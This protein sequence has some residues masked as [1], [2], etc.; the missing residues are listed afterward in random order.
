MNHCNTFLDFS[1]VRKYI[2]A[3]FYGNFASLRG[4]FGEDEKPW[5]RQKP[6]Q[7]SNGDN[8]KIFSVTGTI[9]QI[10]WVFLNICL[11]P[12]KKDWIKNEKYFQDLR[13]FAWLQFSCTD[14]RRFKTYK[15]SRIFSFWF[16]ALINLN[17]QGC[18]IAIAT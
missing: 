7:L 5:T 17:Y 15:Y 1:E 10:I 9:F 11:P 3:S 14:A 6:N 16:D 8:A 18:Y 2:F 13:I 12:A 4:H